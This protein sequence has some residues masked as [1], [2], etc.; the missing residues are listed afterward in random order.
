MYKNFLDED[1][2]VFDNR[3]NGARQALTVM[4][5]STVCRTIE[6][7][8]V[9]IFSLI[10]KRRTDEQMELIKISPDYADEKLILPENPK[11]VYFSPKNNTRG[12]LSWNTLRKWGVTDAQINEIYE[13]GYFMQYHERATS[14]TLIPSKAFL[15]TLCRQIGCGKLEEGIEPLRDIYLAS[16][17]RDAEPFIMVYRTNGRIGK[18]FGCFSTSFSHNPQTIAFEFKHELSKI[19]PVAIRSWRV[20]HFVS[21]ID[22]MFSELS[23]RIGGIKLTPGVRLIMSDV[24]D[25]SYSLQNVIFLN[26]GMVLFNKAVSKR[27]LGKL[28]VKEMTET[29]QKNIKD[30]F[31]VVFDSLKKMEQK[32]IDNVKKAIIEIMKSI[33]FSSAYGVQNASALKKQYIKNMKE[34]PGT[35]FDAVKF[36]MRIPGMIRNSASLQQFEIVAEAAGKALKP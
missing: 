9:T 21:R 36:V 3:E 5:N 17:L 12:T 26:G 34:K 29:Y 14:I 8:G 35:E 30:E 13:R 10:S 32:P 7:S 31:N 6:P 11:Q 18:A 2:E 16:K 33:G 15:A 23:Q 28:D 22:F 20:N 19:S 24:G 4:S 1:F 25:A 27:H